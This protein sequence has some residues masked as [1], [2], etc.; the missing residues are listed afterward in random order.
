MATD[1]APAPGKATDPGSR[2]RDN[3]LLINAVLW[4]ARSG[5]PWRDLPERYGEWNP[6]YQRFNRW[7][8]RGRGGSISEALQEPDLEWLMLD[9]TTVRAHQHAACDAPGNPL[10]FLLTPGQRGGLTQAGALLC[11]REPG[12]VIAGRGHDA[13]R[14]IEQVELLKAEV[15]IPGKRNRLQQREIDRNLYAGRDKIERLFNRL[16][17]Y[18]RVATRYEKTGR[19]YLAFIHLAATVTLLL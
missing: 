14:L 11:G 17:H 19:N 16:K 13:D 12:A 2:A 5:A 7:A 3:R 15:V 10:Q 9:S 1:R 6:I 18:R 4:I 8:K